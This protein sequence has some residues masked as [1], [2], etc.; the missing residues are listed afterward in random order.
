MDQTENKDKMKKNPNRKASKK[1]SWL[2]NSQF[3]KNYE[4]NHFLNLTY[5]N[6]LLVFY[7]L[8]L[9]CELERT[10]EEF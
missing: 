4:N 1:L 2:K 8:Q 9:I 7:D 6:C 10:N 3:G 5:T